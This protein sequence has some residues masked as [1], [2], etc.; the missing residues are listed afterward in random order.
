MARCSPDR[1]ISDPVMSYLAV[2]N[3]S[4]PAIS[5]QLV[6]SKRRT[7]NP[8][9]SVFNSKTL[10]R[11][12]RDKTRKSS[13]SASREELIR[14]VRKVISNELSD[15]CR[16]SEFYPVYNLTCGILYHGNWKYLSDDDFDI[17]VKGYGVTAGPKELKLASIISIQNSMLRELYYSGELNPINGISITSELIQSAYD[18]DIAMSIPESHRYSLLWES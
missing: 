17:F 2:T 18:P 3:L 8:D 6:L 13:K 5:M 10:R 12:L 1:F 7:E 11:I 14:M 16:S 9:P 4:L 15:G